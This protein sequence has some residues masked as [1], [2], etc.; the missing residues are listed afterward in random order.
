M[1]VEASPTFSKLH[2]YDLFT[3]LGWVSNKQM[4]SRLPVTL[5]PSRVTL[6]PEL[7]TVTIPYADDSTG[8]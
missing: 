4:G 6:L 5:N 1:G 2:R 8:H 3:R 7:G